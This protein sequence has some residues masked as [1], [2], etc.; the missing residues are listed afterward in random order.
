MNLAIAGVTGALIGSSIAAA[1][2]RNLARQLPEGVAFAPRALYIPPTG[3][4]S[5]GNVKVQATVSNN[6]D[7]PGQFKLIALVVHESCGISG[8]DGYRGSASGG[9]SKWEQM[10]SWIDSHPGYGAY[11]YLPDSWHTLDAQGYITLETYHPTTYSIRQ[12]GYY[13]VWACGAVRRVGETGRLY[14]REYYSWKARA[15]NVV[16]AAG[17]RSSVSSPILLNK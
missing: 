15:N 17:P 8:S 9:S 7:E 3:A 16:A 6:G 5:P 12:S 1:T 10:V 2:L 13:H 14:E 4:I 11:C